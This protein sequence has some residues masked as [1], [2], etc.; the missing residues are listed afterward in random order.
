MNHVEGCAVSDIIA[1]ND[2]V[3][4]VVYARQGDFPGTPI[5]GLPDLKLVDL[6]INNYGLDL[7]INAY[8]YSEIFL[9]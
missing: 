3:S 4:A 5:N 8:G 7:E 9:E 6:F 1:H 2:A